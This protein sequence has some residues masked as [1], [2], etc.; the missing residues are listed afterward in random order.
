MNAYTKQPIIAREN[1]DFKLDESIPKYWFGNDPFKTRYFDAVMATFP[2]GERFFISAVRAFRDQ[3]TDPKLAQDVK[4]FSRQE[5]QHGILHTKLIQLLKK[6]NTPVESIL[7]Q[8]RV[9]MNFML[10]YYPAKFN[11]AY[12]A[13]CEHVTALMAE[14]FFGD[15]AVMAEA[16][17]HIRALLAWHSIEEMEH[18]AVAFDVMKDVANV[19]EPMR[20]FSMYFLTVLFATFS[21]IDTDRFLKADGFSLSERLKMYR[22][23]LPWMYGKEGVLRKLTAS[24]KAYLKKDFHPWQIPVVENYQTWLDVYAETNDPLAAGEAFYQAAK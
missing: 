15:K 20:V 11:L 8:Q 16:H 23:G 17:P 9:F 19:S 1:L 24:W 12:T 10:K 22:K 14:G 21:F 18:K 5:G 4:E 6:Q 2:E 3:I 7:K 13:A